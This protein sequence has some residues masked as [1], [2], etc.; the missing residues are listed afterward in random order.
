MAE[1]L[2]DARMPWYKKGPPGLGKED[3]RFKVDKTKLMICK[4]CALETGRAGLAT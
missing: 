2:E 4:K 1:Y 3:K